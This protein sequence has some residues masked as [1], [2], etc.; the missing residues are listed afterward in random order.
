[1]VDISP[2]EKT[3]RKLLGESLKEWLVLWKEEQESI[4]KELINEDY[5]KNWVERFEDGTLF[6]KEV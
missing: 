4:R 2:L 6:K 1:M 3:T 5:A